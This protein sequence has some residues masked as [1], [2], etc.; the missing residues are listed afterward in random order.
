MRRSLICKNVVFL[1]VIVC[2][3]MLCTSGCASR[4]YV[5]NINGVQWS[6]QIV[7][8]KVYL[9]NIG[10]T[11]VVP[12][13]T[14]GRLKIPAKIGEMEVARIGENAFKNCDR[15]TVVELPETI[16][17]C[18]VY[19]F[20]GCTSLKAVYFHGNRPSLGYD[21]FLETHPDGCYDWDFPVIFHTIRKD[22]WT[23]SDER[24][25]SFAVDMS[26]TSLQQLKSKVN[27]EISSI[28]ITY[29]DLKE[30]FDDYDRGKKVIDILGSKG[31]TDAQRERCLS[32]YHSKHVVIEGRVSDVSDFNGRA[33]IDLIVEMVKYGTEL[34]PYDTSVTRRKVDI[35]V[36]SRKDNAS[37]YCQ[38]LSKGDN[39]TVRGTLTASG[40]WHSITDAETVVGWMEMIE[41][42]EKRKRLK[43]CISAV[44]ALL[45]K[46]TQCKGSGLIDGIVCTTCKGYGKCAAE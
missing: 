19:A 40:I 39:L 29:G 38:H 46:C 9:Q 5:E 28:D 43:A 25:K 30:Y 6:Y 21:S 27:E 7:G 12:I 45:G 13:G 20:R 11:N 44:D 34:N 14:S 4:D 33:A 8:N 36:T 2:A 16:V 31:L 22:G 24:G 3:L 42:K 15:I 26:D 17:E 32:E 18:N 35:C 1:M 41:T 37:S 23:D 10:G